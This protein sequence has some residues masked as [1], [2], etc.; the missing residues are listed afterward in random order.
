MK[1]SATAFLVIIF[2]LSA[3]GQS[4]PVPVIENATST[5][6][7]FPS[8]TSSPT[9]TP[10][11][12]VTPLPT[13]P[14]FTPTFDVSTI[15]TVTPA[16]KAECPPVIQTHQKSISLG[17]YP[18]GQKYVDSPEPILDYLNQGGK[19]QDVERELSDANI[20]HFIADI[21][22][23]DVPDLITVYGA[24]GIHQFVILFWCE[25]GKYNYFPKDLAETETLLSA[26]VDGFSINDLNK[27]GVPDV[28]S[29]GDG[30]TELIVNIL[31]WDGEKFV[32]LT[33][34]ETQ[35][36]AWASY[37]GIDDFQ[38][39]DLNNDGIPEMILEGHANYWYFPGEPFRS[40]TQIYRWN[41][42]YYS[43]SSRYSSPKYRFQEIQDGD[44]LTAKGEYGEAINLYKDALSSD[45]LDW[46]SKERYEDQVNAA[47]NF[48]TPPAMEPDLTEYPRLAAYAYYRIML[49]H[50][51][52][53]NE[54][55][56]TTYNTLLETFGNDPYAHPYVE[57]AS[58]FWEAYQSTHKMYDGCAAAIQYAV[59]HPEI[60]IPLGSD[61]HGAQS[62]IYVPADVC[63]FR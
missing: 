37:A 55:A 45:K 28:L 60:L 56:L 27:N 8:N 50:L 14:T 62:H 41:G 29:I 35:F 39:V 2:L 53:G 54:E 32:D 61:Y 47:T 19:L 9:H 58:A 13:I 25:R 21:T 11:A 34:S 17:S 15:V 40:R 16:P 3:C 20:S 1:R 44:S 7:A 10:T 63:P 12:S 42:K 31:E 18:S 57:M 49:L 52:Q 6:S 43:E 24:G 23:D 5:P 38:L 22:N 33:A 51:V 4:A 59:E 46:W 30:R 26:T 48:V 36:N